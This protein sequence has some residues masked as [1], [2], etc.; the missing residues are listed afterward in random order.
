MDIECLKFFHFSLHRNFNHYFQ[1]LHFIYILNITVYN[2][3]NSYIIID[4]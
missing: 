4:I 3:L 1:K 2:K